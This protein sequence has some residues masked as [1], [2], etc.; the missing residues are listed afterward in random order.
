MPIAAESPSD[1]RNLRLSS[2]KGKPYYTLVIRT[3]NAHS[4]HRRRN[5]RVVSSTLLVSRRLGEAAGPMRVRRLQKLL[6]QTM[7]TESGGSSAAPC[8][9]GGSTTDVWPS[10]ASSSTPLTLSSAS[11]TECTGGGSLSVVHFCWTVRFRSSRRIP[12]GEQ[13]PKNP[14]SGRDKLRSRRL[15]ASSFASRPPFLRANR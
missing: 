15:D 10:L 11:P 3:S 6:S 8:L 4:V 9:L 7:K 1:A 2:R 13:H 14:S 5:G 12:R